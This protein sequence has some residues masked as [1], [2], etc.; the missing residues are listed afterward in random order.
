MTVGKKKVVELDRERDR[1]R[2]LRWHYKRL[3]TKARAARHRPKK[4][5]EAAS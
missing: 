2:R 1:I 3:P 4:R 5:R